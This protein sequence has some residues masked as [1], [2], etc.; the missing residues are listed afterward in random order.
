MNWGAIEA[1]G[2]TP[3]A[4]AVVISLGYVAVQIRQNTNETR[5]QR[6][7]SLISADADANFQLANNESLAELFQAGVRDYQQ[8][9]GSDQ[10]RFGALTFSA[11]NR[12]KQEE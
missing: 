6:N 7:Q 3:G 12:E 9:S 11:F 5:M 8:L 10:M 2:E 4:A 1:V